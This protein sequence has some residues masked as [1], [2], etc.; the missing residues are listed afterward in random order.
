MNLECSSHET[1]ATPSDLVSEDEHGEQLVRPQENVLKE[2]EARS[3]CSS[4]EEG[5]KFKMRA[6]GYCCFSREWFERKK[7]NVQ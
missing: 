5:I 4:K 2:K 7:Q 6:A 3:Y 1:D